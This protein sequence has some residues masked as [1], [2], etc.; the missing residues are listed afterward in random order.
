[1]EERLRAGQGN[2]GEESRPRRG[3]LR[4]ARAWTSFNRARGTSGTDAEAHDWTN[5]AGY[6]ASAAD[7]RD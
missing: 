6:L 2:S 4:H 5:S 1:V 7:R 3:G